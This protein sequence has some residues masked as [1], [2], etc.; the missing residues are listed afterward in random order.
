MIAIQQTERNGKVVAATLVR[1]D[2]EIMLITDS[3]VLVRTRVAEI[4][5]LGRATQG[6][7]LIALDDGAKLIGLQ[8]IVE[9]D[10][11]DEP[12][13]ADRSRRRPTTKEKASEPQRDDRPD[14]R[15]LPGASSPPLGARRTTHRDD[16][17]RRRARRRRSWCRSILQLQQPEIESVARSIVERPAA[18]MMQEAGLA[19]QRQVPP[20]K[21]EAMG[22]AIEAEVKKY[23]D[24]SVSAGARAGAQARAVDARRGARGEV[25]RGRAEA[26]ARLAR[27]AGEQEIP[28]AGPEMRNTFV[29]K[30]LAESIAAVDPKVRRSTAGSASSSACR[31]RRQGAAASGPPPRRAPR[32]AARASGRVGPTT[33]S[34]MA[35]TAPG[36]EQEI[37]VLREQIDALDRELLALLN[38]R[39]GVAR[40]IGELKQ[41]RRL[42]GVPARARGRR[43]STA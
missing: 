30:V 29:Q 1:P 43:S 7:T 39:A 5:E 13:T 32:P 37:G 11:A 9:N 27:V 22:K 15:R 35:S 40:A 12:G 28:A 42:A 6:V 38:R 31:R 2:D 23:V 10:A 36:R 26:A 34:R 17:A 19:M 25:Q 20:D 21:R 4:R 8:R 18:Q 41:R 14:R 33:R 3:G 24:E 16:D